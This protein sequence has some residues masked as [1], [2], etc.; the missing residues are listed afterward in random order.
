MAVTVN[1]GNQVVT[2]AY[3]MEATGEGFSSGLYKSMERGVYTP[4]LLTTDESVLTIGA[5]TKIVYEDTS[6][7][8][9]VAITLTED[10]SI[11]N[12]AKQYIIGRYTWE[13]GATTNYMTFLSVAQTSVLTDDI[14][15]GYYDG[16]NWYFDNATIPTTN[17]S[18]SNS[19]YNFELY[20]YSAT[21]IGVKTGEGYYNGSLIELSSELTYTLSSVY[22][23]TSSKPYLLFYINTSNALVYTLT[24]TFK[25]DLS[26]GI[27][28]GYLSYDST[29]TVSNILPACI[30]NLYYTH[31]PLISNTVIDTS[32]S[33]SSSNGI[34]NAVVSSNINSIQSTLTTHTSNISSLSTSLATLS[35]TVSSNYSTL[36]SGINSKLTYNSTTL[37]Y[38]ASSLYSFNQLS[39]G[40]Y[41]VCYNSSSSPW[42]NVPVTSTSS[43]HWL[44]GTFTFGT[45]SSKYQFACPHNSSVM[46]FRRYSSSWT[47]WLTIA[48]TT[49]VSNCLATAKSYALSLFET[50]S[51]RLD[52]VEGIEVDDMV[53]EIQNLG[54]DYAFTVGSSLTLDES[55]T[56]LSS[57]ASSINTAL[58]S[59]SSGEI[60]TI[61]FTNATYSVGCLNKNHTYTPQN[62]SSLLSWITSLFNV[63]SSLTT[64]CGTIYA[65]ILKYTFSCNSYTTYQVVSQYYLTSSTSEYWNEKS[66]LPCRTSVR[67]KF[68]LFRL[69]F[70]AFKTCYIP[71]KR[72]LYLSVYTSD[73]L[74]YS[75]YD[76]DTSSTISS[77]T[78]CPFMYLYYTRRGKKLS[79]SRV[80][81]KAYDTNNE[82]LSFWKSNVNIN[83]LNYVESTNSS[84]ETTLVYN[85]YS[86]DN[87]D[88]FDVSNIPTYV[89]PESCGSIYNRLTLDESIRLGGMNKYG[90]FRVGCVK[91]KE[92]ATASFTY[93]DSVN[94]YVGKLI[95]S[96]VNEYVCATDTA[97]CNISYRYTN[98]I[99]DRY[100]TGAMYNNIGKIT[101]SSISAPNHTTLKQVYEGDYPIIKLYNGYLSRGKAIAYDILSENNTAH[102]S[103]YFTYKA[104]SGSE[105][106]NTDMYEYTNVLNKNET[107]S[108]DYYISPVSVV[109]NNTYSYYNFAISSMSV[110]FNKT[111]NYSVLLNKIAEFANPEDV[112]YVAQCSNGNITASYTLANT[113]LYFYKTLV[114]ALTGI[115]PAYI[116]PV[117]LS[118]G[119]YIDV[120]DNVLTLRYNNSFAGGITNPN[121]YFTVDSVTYGYYEDGSQVSLYNMY[122]PFD[123][124]QNY[125]GYI[126]RFR[127]QNYILR[128]FWNKSNKSSYTS[129]NGIRCSS[130]D[131]ESCT[132]TDL[133]YHLIVDFPSVSIRTTAFD[134]KYS[135]TDTGTSTADSKSITYYG[136]T[137]SGSTSSISKTIGGSKRVAYDIPENI[138]VSYS[139]ATDMIFVNESSYF[140]K[141]NSILLLDNITNYD[142]S[143]CNVYQHKQAMYGSYYHLLGE[144]STEF[145]DCSNNEVPNNINNYNGEI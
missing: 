70:P 6:N 53:K 115:N 22:L 55:T 20:R 62:Y 34:S 87:A 45:S 75:Y 12:T 132:I 91:F 114:S 50:N 18:K 136:N 138:F 90:M 9:S 7:Y 58:T 145:S 77:T 51:E 119:N 54:K 93:S 121:V 73:T 117:T 104:S 131:A 47:S 102:A 85:T 79:S 30:H 19:H 95:G 65:H 4:E 106:I 123:N 40:I 24:S 81:S 141:S 142:A 82:A 144:V 128:Q 98:F 57:M 66:N 100:E 27:P 92:S 38:S 13:D 126:N 15:L 48:T 133:N 96:D 63:N 42:E 124:N 110:Y 3:G 46:Y 68:D 61:K 72:K 113:H 74:S 69:N 140:R 97:T 43:Q 78:N 118:S 10:Y 135:P 137:S 101:W 1:A 28:I 2:F 52:N 112:Y 16:T 80:S 139:P 83:T 59:L 44:V 129:V 60:L 25:F 116:T 29:Q 94:Y 99:S 8:I 84:T 23:P 67:T 33:T 120:S 134:Y 127:N 32:L 76:R 71:E 21:Q 105:F 103:H 49:N 130:S 36:L 56:T 11:T 111:T 108:D 86:G 64:N 5:G 17:R 89:S 109:S 14:I 107:N 26:K 31:V 39:N 35:S 122:T 143:L 88:Y 125:H 41:T 37:T